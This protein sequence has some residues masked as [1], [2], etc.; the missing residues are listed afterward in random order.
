MGVNKNTKK[1]VLAGLIVALYLQFG[2]EPTGWLF[3][4][5]SFLLG[6]DWL[7][8]GYSVFRGLGYMFS[9]WA[10]QPLACVAAGGLTAVLVFRRG[11][12]RII[13]QE[14]KI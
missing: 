7:Y 5:A 9:L 3:Y 2:L 13:Q 10:Y 6:L 4:E 14:N 12:R 11:S 8:W 1:A